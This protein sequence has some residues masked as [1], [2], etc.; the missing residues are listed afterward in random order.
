MSKSSK[1]YQAPTHAEISSRA[2]QI[3]EREGRPEGKAME[4]WLQA[5]AQL[6]AQ[7]KSE[8]SQAAAKS[9]PSMSAPEK[10]RGTTPEHNPPQWS[11]PQQ[12]QGVR[13]A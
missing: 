6:T 9:T 11:A 1:A 5:E 7:R 4:H 13:K 8:A 10:N 12:R 3:Y 2:Q